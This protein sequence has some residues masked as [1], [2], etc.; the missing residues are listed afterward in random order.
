MTAEKEYRNIVDEDIWN[1][2]RQILTEYRLNIPGF[3]MVG[4][5]MS[6]SHTKILETHIHKNCMEIVYVVSGS[7]KYT[8]DG[9]EYVVNGNQLFIAP[10]D[11]PHSSGDMPHG[12]Y[13]IYMMKIYGDYRKSFLHMTEPYAKLL[14][15]AVLTLKGPVISPA[16]NLK[17]KFDRM[18]YELTQN[19]LLQNMHGR[20]LLQE[21]LLEI[22]ASA[23]SE[24]PTASSTIS[25]AMN[26]I[27][28]NIT[29]EITLEEL[30]AYCGLSL[31]RFKQRFREEMGI[32]PR[33]YINIKKIE[34]AKRLLRE[35]VG[36]TDTAFGL[37]FSS[38]TYFS[39]VFKKVVGMSPKDYRKNNSN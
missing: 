3:Q 32:A 39:V 9:K 21:L 34:E 16:E 18:F 6:E 1:S 13:D 24:Y 30:A 2:K 19:D 11:V 31:S 15:T 12:R 37:G 38:S 35:G 4:R 14:H 22:C 23:V 5:T 25:V 36:I 8:I 7:Q 28:K 20:V 33:E 10:P 26:F 29:E 27:A 17:H